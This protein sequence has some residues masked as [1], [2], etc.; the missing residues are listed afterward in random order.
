MAVSEQLKALVDRMPDPDGRGMYTENI[1]KDRI[2]KAVAEIAAGG[3]KHVEM[4]VEMLGAPGTAENVKPHYALHCVINYPLIQGDQKMRKEFC[5][6]LA[7][8]LGD[9]SLSDYNRGYLCQ[10]LQWAGRDEACPALGKVLLN[11]ALVEPACM[12]L[13]AIGGERA[14][15]ELLAALP[16]ASGKC[17]LNIIDALA[18]IPA[19]GAAEA[20]LEALKDGDG[21]VRLAAGAGLAKLGD[22]SAAGAL[23]EAADVEP[24]WERTQQTKHCL[25]L[26]EKLAAAGQKDQAKKIYRHLRD[27]R[28]DGGEKYIRDAVEAAG[29][30]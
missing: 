30:L 7:S 29:L 22:A 5:Q 1:D 24:G 6:V 10:E 11:E 13:A 15:R 12:A 26:A 18:A 9:E 3:R 21:E 4:L 25:V 23:L 28:T 2:E 16:R 8:K 20:F 17:R 19:G 27:T 14:A